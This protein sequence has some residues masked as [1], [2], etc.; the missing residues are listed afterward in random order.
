[1]DISEFDSF[2]FGRLKLGLTRAGLH[3]PAVLEE[4]GEDDEED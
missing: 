1:M 4:D 2:A 3:E